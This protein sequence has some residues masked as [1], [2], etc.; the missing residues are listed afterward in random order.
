[1]KT[2]L[3]LFDHSGNWSQPYRENGYNVIQV[4]IEHGDDIMTYDYKSIGPV[5]GILAA[6]PCT[7][8]SASGAVWW[9]AK[10]RDGRTADHIRLYVKVFDIIADLS[11]Q[12]WVLENPSGR[13]PKFFPKLGRPWY[14]HPCDFGDA[15]TKKTG[16]WGNFIP[17]LPLF[18]GHQAVAPIDNPDPRHH[19]IDHYMINVK[20]VKSVGFEA[21]A[22]WRSKT[23]LGFAY[24]FYEVNK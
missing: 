9:P 4:D 2:I 8:M 12:F 18:V 23:P 22:E 10:D 6:P 20:K 1:M 24:A 15:Y 16:L 11:P 13:L 5:Y 7:H 21:R 17:P 3:S 14:F 19:S